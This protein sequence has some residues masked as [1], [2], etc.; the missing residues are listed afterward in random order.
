MKLFQEPYIDDLAN[1]PE[2]MFPVAWLDEGADIDQENI[3]KIKSMVSMH[4]VCSTCIKQNFHCKNLFS[5]SLI[6]LVGHSTLSIHVEPI[7]PFLGHHK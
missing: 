6:S 4:N 5:N 7:W 1:V 2:L 3:D